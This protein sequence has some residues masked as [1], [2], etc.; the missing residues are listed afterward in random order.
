MAHEIR[1]WL[2]DRLAEVAARDGNPGTELHD[3]VVFREAGVDAVRAA[4]LIAAL[5]TW[6]G[7]E[8]DV[9]LL[10][11]HP[12]VHALA[13]ALTAAPGTAAVRERASSAGDAVAI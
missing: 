6:L 13:E 2:I 4:Q 1:G 11:D 10:Y 9:T 7:R 5:G 12:T 3:G 8:L